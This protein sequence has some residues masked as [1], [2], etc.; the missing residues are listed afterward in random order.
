MYTRVSI[1]QLKAVHERTHPARLRRQQAPTR[2][3]SQGAIGGPPSVDHAPADTEG[4]AAFLA[5]LQRQ[6]ERDGGGDAPGVAA[7]A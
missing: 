6:A 3:A 4:A 5:A 2:E 1:M 7:D